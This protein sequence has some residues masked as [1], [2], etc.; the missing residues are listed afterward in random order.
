MGVT[1]WWPDL[2]RLIFGSQGTIDGVCQS[3]DFQCT[4][5]RNWDCTTCQ[6]DLEGINQAFNSA[7]GLKDIVSMLQGEKFC[8][9]DGMTS[10]EQQVAAC[11]SYVEAFMPYAVE[12]LGRELLHNSH[13][14]CNMLYGV[15]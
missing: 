3:M 13:S 2:A 10:N 8:E 6:Y 7:Q 1:L 4:G 15:C 11:K 5:N 14:I 9:K 12:A